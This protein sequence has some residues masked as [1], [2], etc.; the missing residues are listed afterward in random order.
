MTEFVYNNANNTSSGHMLFKLNCGFHPWISYK[1]NVKLYFKSKKNLY[2]AKKLQ[3]W[4]YNKDIKY[5]IYSSN[6]KFRLN[7]KYIK[8]KQNR[9]L[10]TKFFGSF[11]VL[12]LVCKQVYK[13]KLSR[14]LFF[15]YYYWSRILPRKSEWMIT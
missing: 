8:T 10:E 15:T 13:L 4:A 7:S 1:K 14:K 6:N 11:Q 3:K 12:H 2:Y 5:K 9:K